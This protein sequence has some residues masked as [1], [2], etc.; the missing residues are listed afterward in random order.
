MII[1]EPLLSLSEHSVGMHRD[2]GE[3]LVE[4]TE[5]SR[6]SSCK[7]LLKEGRR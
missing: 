4:E 5:E 2:F 3:E 7:R 6:V 1:E